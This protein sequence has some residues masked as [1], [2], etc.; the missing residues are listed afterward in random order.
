MPN[1]AE[2]RDSQR[3]TM[4]LEGLVD[5][6][7]E[8]RPVPVE[9]A[10]VSVGGCRLVG[11]SA[12]P[13]T[14]ARLTIDARDGHPPIE[15][16]VTV[17]REVNPGRPDAGVGVRFD[18]P[19]PMSVENRLQKAI[20]ALEREMARAQERARNDEADDETARPGGGSA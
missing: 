11:W 2:K 12:P 17:M 1:T 10:D 19:Y 4:H 18:E 5:R 8:P 15:L 20:R 13:G 14:R 16:R 3:L 9:I 6:H 7:S